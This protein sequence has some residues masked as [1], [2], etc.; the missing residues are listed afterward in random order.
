MRYHRVVTLAPFV[1][2]LVGVILLTAFGTLQLQDDPI[3]VPAEGHAPAIYVSSNRADSQLDYISIATG[4]V[5]MRNPSAV[6]CTEMGYEFQIKK[7][8]NGETGL[9]MMPDGEEC[10]SWSFYSGECGQEYSYCTR[11]GLDVSD[12]KV[13]DAF[14]GECTACV[15]PNG[16]IRAVSQLLGLNQKSATGVLTVAEYLNDSEASLDIRGAADGD[17][18]P[19]FFDWRNADGVNWMTPVKDQGN[20]GSCWAFSAVG[21]VEAIY[22]IGYSNPDLDLNLSEQYLVTDCCGP[23]GH[24]CGG[25]PYTSLEFIRDNG[26]PDEN[27]FPY[28]DSLCSCRNGSCNC[29]YSSPCCSNAVCSDR[30][31]DWNNRLVTIDSTGSIAANIESIKQSLIQR[32]PAS[33]VMGYGDIVGG[34]WDENHVY[35]CTDDEW[36]NHGIVIAGYDDTEGYWIVKNSWGSSW[37]DGGYFKVGFEECAIE[38]WP[39]YAAIA[40]PTPTATATATATPTSTAAATA[41]PTATPR[42]LIEVGYIFDDYVGGDAQVLKSPK[43]VFVSG[44]YA[45][46]ASNGDCG[47][48]I[49]DISDPANPVEV[50]YLQDDSRGGN[51]TYMSLPYNIFVRGD[52]AYFPSWAEDALTIIDVSDPANPTEVGFIRDYRQPGGTA[53]RLDGAS[54]VEVA[55]NYAYVTTDKDWGLT[56]I[57]IS[58]PTNPFEVGHIQDEEKGG[59]AEGMRIMAPVFVSGEYAYVGSLADDAISIIDIS[60]PSNP[61]QVGV[62]YDDESPQEGI[63]PNARCID[64]PVGIYVSGDYAYIGSR[65]DSALSILD[66]SDPANPI[67]VG[68]I[69]DD[70]PVADNDDTDY[71]DGEAHALY[72]ANEVWVV[73]DYAFVASYEGALSMIDVSDPTNPVEVDYIKDDSQGG[74]AIALQRANRLHIQGRYAY[75]TG[76]YD[77][78]LSIIELPIGLPTPTPTPTPAPLPGDANGDGVINAADITKIERIILELDP[79]TPGADANG[80]GEVD[81]ADIGVI[82]YMML[83]I[84]P[85]NHVHVEA[86]SSLP[87]DTHFTATVFITYVEGFGSAGFELTYNS[88]VL[89]LEGVSNGKLMQIDPGVSADFYTVAIGWSQPGGP[90]TLLVNAGIDGNPGPSGAGYLAQLHFHVIGSAG[91]SSAI[92]FNETQSWLRDSL[93]EAID[94]TWAGD[95][96]TVAP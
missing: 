75:V 18:L 65:H 54:F 45:Y 22:N 7:T 85:W 93:G 40:T 30:C 41:T 46:I 14:T 9:C 80:D 92:A 16:S 29:S 50:G 6:Y 20:C 33:V 82:E 37:E 81:A 79:K 48:S 34:Y 94:C 42:F 91:Q 72:M 55:G 89:D 95:S 52:Y 96:V 17:P 63:T 24:C 43:G 2:I 13:A 74:T 23:C 64:L 3:N 60:D 67:E 4:G 78:S 8:I 47:M 70:D 51:G 76:Y 86:P 31:P 58:D 32:G 26:I 59:T 61:V 5:G 83:G 35:R 25:W 77:H 11:H 71:P 68:C 53:E 19:G 88:A 49:I 90:G 87:Y 27:C 1:I 39:Y 38:G 73:G 66:I 15:M 28:V 56:I 84:W 44:Q 36:I 10:D 57:N 12:I 21:V 69:Q 62:I